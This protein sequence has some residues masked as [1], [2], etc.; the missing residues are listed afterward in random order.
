MQNAYAHALVMEC[1]D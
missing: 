1:D